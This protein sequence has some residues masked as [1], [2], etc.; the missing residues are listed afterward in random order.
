VPSAIDNEKWLR[1]TQRK[2]G[3]FVELP[4]H[5]R[6]HAIFDEAS[7]AKADDTVKPLSLVAGIKRLFGLARRLEKAGK[8]R[9]GL[10]FHGLR[11]TPGRLLADRGADPRTIAA[12]AR[13]QD[14]GDGGAL[15]RRSRSQKRAAAAV[16]KLRPGTKVSNARGKSV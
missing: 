15:Q 8:V 11:H 4:V 16:S 3:T 14:V 10:T 5:P 2:T 1:W 9:A 6:L 7:A 12:V 13:P